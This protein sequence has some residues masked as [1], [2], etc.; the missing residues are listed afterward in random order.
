MACPDLHFVYNIR[1]YTRTDT[2]YTHLSAEIENTNIS[3]APP[4]RSVHP[5]GGGGG[6]RRSRTESFDA[7]H[8]NVRHLNTHWV[9]QHVRADHAPMPPPLYAP[10]PLLLRSSPTAAGARQKVRAGGGSPTRERVDRRS[11][12]HYQ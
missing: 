3:A 11:T 6:Q 7:R 12:R 2:S 5:G 9:H 4:H 1:M 10:G 8:S